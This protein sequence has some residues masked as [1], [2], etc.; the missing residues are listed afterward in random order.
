MRWPPYKH[1]FFDCDSTLTTVEGIDVLAETA[2][3]K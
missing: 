1:V 3:K 2:G